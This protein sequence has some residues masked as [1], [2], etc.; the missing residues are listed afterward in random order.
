[1]VQRG[2]GEPG[3]LDRGGGVAGAAGR[4]QLVDL[5]LLSR[6]DHLGELDGLRV[7]AIALFIP[8]QLDHPRVMPSA[9]GSGQ[10]RQV[11]VLVALLERLLWNELWTAWCPLVSEFERV[12]GDP[13]MPFHFYGCGTAEPEWASR[14]TDDDRRELTALLA[15][16][17]DE[18]E[19]IEHWTLVGEEL[20]LLAGERG[21]TRL[22]FALLLKFS[23]FPPTQPLPTL[24]C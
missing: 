3:P 13:P 20:E 14:L 24:P 1:V 2:D 17:V 22:A 11:Q 10:A 15:R 19:L 21:P 5:R 12:D 8:P 23:S 16:T 9:L 7:Q 4:T 18:D 6:K